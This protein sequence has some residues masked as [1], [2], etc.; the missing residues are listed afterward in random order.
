MTSNERFLWVVISHIEIATFS[1]SHYGRCTF[2]SLPYLHNMRCRRTDAVPFLSAKVVRGFWLSKGPKPLGLSGKS[3][4]RWVVFSAKTLCKPAPLPLF[5]YKK[6]SAYSDLWTHKKNVAMDKQKVNT[7]SSMNRKGYS[8]S[9]HYSI[10]VV[11]I[12]FWA[13]FALP[14]YP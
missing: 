3:P 13:L 7:T 11:K 8:S 10:N 2:A 5:C 4:H 1:I 12:T 14:S 6:E 9:S